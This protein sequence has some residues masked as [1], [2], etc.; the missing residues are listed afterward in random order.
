MSQAGA[1]AE[2]VEFIPMLAA[3]LLLVSCAL[4][5]AIIVIVLIK[6]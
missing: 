1:F 3:F 2:L 5:F 4:A 6:H